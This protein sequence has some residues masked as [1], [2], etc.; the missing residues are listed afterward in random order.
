MSFVSALEDASSMACTVVRRLIN[1]LKID[2]NNIGRIEVA[3]ETLN[4]KSKSTKTILMRMFKN[5]NIEG[6]TTFNACYGGTAALIN[7][8][9]YGLAEGRDKLSIVVAT[10]IAVYDTI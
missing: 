5:K 4:D 9:N 7:C 6:V 1:R 8:I 10:D 3:T 2:E